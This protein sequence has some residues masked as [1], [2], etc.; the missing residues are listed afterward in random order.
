MAKAQFGEQGTGYTPSSYVKHAGPLMSFHG[1]R[2]GKTWREE[3][4]R[5]MAIFIYEA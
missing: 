5:Q 3:V 1:R 4:R 2:A